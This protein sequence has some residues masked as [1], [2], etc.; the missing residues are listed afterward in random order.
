MPASWNNFTS[1]S[2]PNVI[3][4]TFVSD[5]HFFDLH[6]LSAPAHMALVL[7]GEPASVPLLWRINLIWKEFKG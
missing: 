5:L 3:V 1:E 7:T 4:F 2:E 6:L